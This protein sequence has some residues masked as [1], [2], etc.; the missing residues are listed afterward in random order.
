MATGG[1]IILNNVDHNTYKYSERK[2]TRYLLARKLQYKIV[3]PGHRNLVK[4]VE[5]KV[6]MLNFPLNWD[7]DIGAENIWG[8]ILDTW[9]ERPQE[10]YATYQRG[11]FAHPNHHPRKI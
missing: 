4:I 5:E 2:Y 9:K 10:K 8:G 3:L 1:G 6:Q 11:N 7:D